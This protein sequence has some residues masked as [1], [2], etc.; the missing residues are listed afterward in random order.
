M[1][2]YHAKPPAGVLAT[3][4]EETL[5]LRGATRARPRWTRRAVTL[6]ELVAVVA[7]LGIFAVVAVSRIGPGTLHNFGARA[8]ARRLAVDLLQARRRS[9][10]TGEN[11]YLAFTVVGGKATSYTLYRRDAG[12]DVAVDSPHEFP[13]NVVVATSHTDAEFTFEGAALAAYQLTLTG[14][15]QTWRV[16]V[17]PVTGTVDVAQTAP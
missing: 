9:I 3:R 11:H 12:G 7:I 16:D 2:A 5:F 4:L 13:A 17:V 10:A 14:A 8:D 1:L 6:L 15:E